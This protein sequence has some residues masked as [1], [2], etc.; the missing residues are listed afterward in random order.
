MKNLLGTNLGHSAI[1]AM[2][3][4][5]QNYEAYSNPDVLRGAIFFISMSLWGPQRV[6]VLKHNTVTVLPAFL[7]VSFIE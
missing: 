5:L 6:T 3:D 7:G 2:L 1:Y 4:M